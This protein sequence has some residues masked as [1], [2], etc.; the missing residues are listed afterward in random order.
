MGWTNERKKSDE[1]ERQQGRREGRC[2][3]EQKKTRWSGAVGLG[4]HALGRPLNRPSAV[5][6]GRNRTAD[7]HQ[8]PVTGN[9]DVKRIKLRLKF[10][11]L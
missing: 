6:R 4:R 10:I 1:P 8:H 7:G 11:V 5:E 3:S 9:L 2:E